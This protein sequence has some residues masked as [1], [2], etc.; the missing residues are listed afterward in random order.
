MRWVLYGATGFTG[1]LIAAEAK[2][3]G[4]RPVLAGRSKEKLDA[5]AAKLGGG[6]EVAAASLDDSAAI[7]KVVDGAEAVLH[8]AGP[9]ERTAKPMREACLKVGAHYLDITG[10]LT[11][12][13]DSFAADSRAKARG[14]AVVSGV[15]FDVV[16]SDCL[17]AQ[18]AAK[19]P[20]ARELEIALAAISQP[21]AG[22]VKS[23]IGIARAGLF[24]LRDGQ[25]KPVTPGR[26]FKRVHFGDRERWVAPFPLGDL[27]TAPRSTGI[28]NVTTYAAISRRTA[29][30]MRLSWPLL[31]LGFPLLRAALGSKRVL[32]RAERFAE[33]RAHGPNERE[34]AA[35]KS[36]IWA[37]AGDKEALL[38][39][40]EGYTYTAHSAVMAVEEAV[41]RR[42]VGAL[43]PSQAFGL[44]FAE[45]VEGTS[46]RW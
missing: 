31:A 42:P 35:G 17:A 45:R 46:I 40:L 12:F 26:G 22:T 21:S 30:A 39:T 38:T 4:Q 6:F 28:S 16:P 34:Q 9:F 37:R 25:L 41:R 27:I 44:D 24:V 20:G 8:A 32:E 13:A 19:A 2:R 29:R 36:M 14:V 1:E 18:L 5:L 11:V 10:E 23:A 43:S 33:R 7:E 15:G 3:R